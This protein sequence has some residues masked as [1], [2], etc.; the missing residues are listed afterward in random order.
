MLASL[1]FAPKQL[2][3]LHYRSGLSSVMDDRVTIRTNRSEIIFRVHLVRSSL[4]RE[5]NYVMDVNET[6][7]IIAINF[8]EVEVANEAGGSIMLNAL[9][10]GLGAPLVFIDDD[11]LL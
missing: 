10:P 11:T 5:R 7:E 2:L 1:G 8:R 4:G 3:D 9:R 6:H